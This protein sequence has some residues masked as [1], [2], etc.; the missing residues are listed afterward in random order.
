M[1]VA[2]VVQVRIIIHIQNGRI[3]KIQPQKIR[4]QHPMRISARLRRAVAQLLDS[5][6]PTL[7]DLVRRMAVNDPGHDGLEA[8]H[9]LVEAE[10]AVRPRLAGRLG[11]AVAVVAND[12]RCHVEGLGHL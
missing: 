5:R 1:E 9:R 11:L 6:E 10:G 12:A 4:R 2:I 8:R 3:S 7:G